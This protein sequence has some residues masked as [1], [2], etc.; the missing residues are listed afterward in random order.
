MT[1]VGAFVSTAAIV[2]TPQV[3]PRADTLA[4]PALPHAI[5]IEAD[6]NDWRF[7]GKAFRGQEERQ[8]HEPAPER[9]VNIEHRTSKSQHRRKPGVAANEFN[10]ERSMLNV[11][12]SLKDSEAHDA[13]V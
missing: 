9:H 5:G 8:Q 11:R 2:S 3:S 12:R 1:G 4:G 6:G 10:V 7:F 13:S